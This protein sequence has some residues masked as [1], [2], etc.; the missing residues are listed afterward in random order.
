[1]TQRAR[2]TRKTPTCSNTKTMSPCLS[3]FP[4]NAN[5]QCSIPHNCIRPQHLDAQCSPEM[6]TLNAQCSHATRICQLQEGFEHTYKNTNSD[7][8]PK[9]SPPGFWFVHFLFGRNCAIRAR[10]NHAMCSAVENASTYMVCH[11]SEWPNS[12]QRRAK[13]EVAPR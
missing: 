13:P 5:A 1:M 9:P 8:L 3:L 7:F 2:D 12:L 10:S 11:L 6:Q 4:R